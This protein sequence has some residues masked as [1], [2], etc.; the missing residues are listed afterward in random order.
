[1]NRGF[2]CLALGLLG[3]AGKIG[4]AEFIVHEWG[5]F[6]SV[7]GSDGRPL[8]GL[9]VEE[10][11]LPNFVHSF[12]GF[13]P[14][15]KGWNRPV[16]GVTIKM[17][18][19]VLYFY[20]PTALSA[21]VD[22]GFN[23]GSISQWYPER[24]GGET[25]P[26]AP[27]LFNARG[28]PMDAP[29]P[30]DFAAG[31]RGRAVWR[32]AVLPPNAPDPVSAPRDWET[33]QWPRARVPGANLV[34]GP[35]GEVEGFIFYRGLGNFR[36]PLEVKSVADG[37]L[38]LQ[39]RGAD[40]LPFVW[41][42][43]KPRLPNASARSWYGRLKP[44]APTTVSGLA[45]ADR[46]EAAFQNALVAAGLTVDEA[47]ALRA[48]W[49]ESYFDHPGLRVFWLVPRALT[50]AVLPIA[51]EPEPTRLERVL[52]GRTEVLTPTFEAELARDFALTAGKRWEGDRYFRAYQ[53]RTRQLGVTVGVAPVAH[54]P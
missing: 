43:E 33:R 38:T 31:H 48:T 54:T 4:A 37:T 42:Y 39:N 19:P 3:A 22:V 8:P 24:V 25:L 47:K 34:R 32:V 1:M 2:M 14:A 46:A 13:A 20:S 52:V 30:V 5:T 28:E 51:I 45:T 50:D 6:T 35:G 17:E 18:T 36:L 10:E 44:G 26:P 41:V 27:L 29:A 11:H 49:Q 12:A 40:D 53:A 15:N 7:V 16:H 23:G 9:E 21:R